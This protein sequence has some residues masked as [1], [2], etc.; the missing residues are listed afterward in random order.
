MRGETGVAS[1]FLAFLS[2]GEQLDLLGFR[3]G[4]GHGED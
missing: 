4:C 3:V 2:A 1:L